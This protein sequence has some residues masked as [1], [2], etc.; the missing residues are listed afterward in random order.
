MAHYIKHSCASEFILSLVSS[1][2]ICNRY[3]YIWGLFCSMWPL[4]TMYIS[5]VKLIYRYVKQ[6][7]L[8]IW[9]WIWDENDIFPV[10]FL[11]A[12][13]RSSSI[14][15]HKLSVSAFAL[16]YCHVDFSRW[17]RELTYIRIKKFFK[18]PDKSCWLILSLNWYQNAYDN[19]VDVSE[20][21]SA[22]YEIQVVFPKNTF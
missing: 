9:I 8:V 6:P 10:K 4:S 14:K 7:Y 13:W 5:K 16:R 3:V 19:N 1:L 12:Y 2:R 15:W 17:S 22:T 20:C 11:R 18:T 21:W